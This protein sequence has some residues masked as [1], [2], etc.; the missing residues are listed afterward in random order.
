MSPLFFASIAMFFGGV[1]PIF[2]KIGLTEL[3]PFISLALRTFSISVILFLYGLISGELS[4]FMT[5]SWRSGLF[6]VAEGVFASLLDHLAYF[7]ALKYDTTS[8]IIPFTA[9]YPIITIILAIIFLGEKITW[10][11][12][13]GAIFVVIGLILLKR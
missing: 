11:K 4:E 5:M 12:G 10:N 9:A 2:G 7:Y 1:A 8:R 3:S 13:L 6:M